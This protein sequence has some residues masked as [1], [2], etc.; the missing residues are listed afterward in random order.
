M[1]AAIKV[2]EVSPGRGARWLVEA[3]GIFRQKPMAWIGLSAG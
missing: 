1:D 3:F 2:A